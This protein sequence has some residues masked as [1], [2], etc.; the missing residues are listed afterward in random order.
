LFA[1]S[2]LISQTIFY[3]SSPFFLSIKMDPSGQHVALQGGLFYLFGIIFFKMDGRIPLAHAIWH[4]FVASGAYTHFVA[5]D[6]YL[7]T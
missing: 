1:S 2:T 7:I 3:I 4:C 6:T 5:I